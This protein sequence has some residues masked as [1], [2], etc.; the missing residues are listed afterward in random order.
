MS[1]TAHPSEDHAANSSNTPT[2]TPAVSATRTE[3]AGVGAVVEIRNVSKVF[4]KLRALDNFTMTINAGETYGLIGPNGSGK[5]TLIRT[6][7]GLTK[8]TSGEV[9]ILGHTMPSSAVAK[10]IGYMPQTSALY[11][12][13]TIRENL[14]FFGSIYGLHGQRLK[15][16]V[17]EV[18]ETVDLADR[19]SSIVETLSGG[20]KQRLSLATAMIHEPRLMLLDEPTVG[21]DPELR[22]SFWEHFARLN[23]K[24]ITIIVSTHHLDEASRCHRLGLMRFGILLAEDKPSELTRLSGKPTME[25]AFLYYATRYKD[26]G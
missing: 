18:L 12:E 20:M 17:D 9:R 15:H 8:P 3:T 22:I 1:S 7:V 16:R 24:G 4:G 25:E 2:S 26:Q 14:I 19:G 5:T 21:I 23:A 13:L 10:D 6:I 11:N